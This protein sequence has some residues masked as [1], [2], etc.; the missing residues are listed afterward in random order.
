MNEE[1]IDMLLLVQEGDLLVQ[2][3]GG[4]PVLTMA[5]LAVLNMTG[6]RQLHMRG[7]G[8]QIMV[9]AV[10]IMA[11]LGAPVMTDTEGKP[12]LGFSNSILSSTEM[13]S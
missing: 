7:V 6:T 2:C 4:V 1:K 13:K 5:V 11:E 8:V 10:R 12:I 9:V 3:T